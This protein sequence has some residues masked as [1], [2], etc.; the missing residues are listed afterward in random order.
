MARSKTHRNYIRVVKTGPDGEPKI[1]WQKRDM[2][3]CPACNPKCTMCGWPY[4]ISTSNE[5]DKFCSAACED[6]NYGRIP[7][8]FGFRRRRA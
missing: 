7:P 1:E 3:D 2:H 8:G 6:A 4:T 5:P